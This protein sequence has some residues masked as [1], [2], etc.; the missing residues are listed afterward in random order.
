MSV[1]RKYRNREW[2]FEQYV[3][4]GRSITDIA[5][6]LGVD[7]TTISK[8]RRKLNIPK[9][10]KKVELE[11]PV[12]G[13]TFTRYKSKVERANHANVCSRTC[14]YEGR[15]LGIIDR[16]VEGGYNVEPTVYQR[17]CK[18]CGG[19]FSTTA[20]EDYQHCS[21]GCFLEAHSD[22]MTGKGNPAY[23]DGSTKEKRCYRGPH[24]AKTR[25]KVYERDNYTCQRC[26]VKCISRK[27]F[28]G[29]NGEK[30]IQAHHINGYESP[31]SN[32]MDNLVTLCASCHGEVEG[33]ASLNVA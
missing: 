7:H 1:T 9:P 14:H 2:L 5:E 22:R 23:I 21:R 31:D 33:G 6:E 29:E 26:G 25:K 30:L 20:T 3:D 15:S 10:S 32:T 24:W 16:D 11:C 27:A 4:K 19:E 18:N 13:D 12:C 8:W 28:N 17:E